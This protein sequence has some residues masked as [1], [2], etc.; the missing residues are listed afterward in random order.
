MNFP[1]SPSS[2]PAGVSSPG[3]SLLLGSAR[4]DGSLPLQELH[5]V[6]NTQLDILTPQGLDAQIDHMKLGKHRNDIHNFVQVRYPTIRV[7]LTTVT[8]AEA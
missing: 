8:V 1:Y 6:E 2:V 3:P 4:A 5:G 7:L